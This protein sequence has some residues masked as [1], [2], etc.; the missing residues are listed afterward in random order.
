M[1][2]RFRGTSMS[3]RQS[4]I[5]FF[6]MDVFGH[7]IRL[8]RLPEYRKFYDKLRARSWEPRTFKILADN[9]DKSITYVDVGAWIGVTSYWASQVAKSV[10]AVEPDPRCNEILRGS[11][12]CYPN[13]TFLSGA[14]SPDPTVKVNAVSGFGSSETTAL[15]I[16]EGESVIVRGYSVEAIMR[17]AG[18]GPCFIKIDIEGYEYNLLTELAKFANYDIKGVQCAVHPQLY[19]KSL[20]GPWFV[21]RLRTLSLTY[22]IARL[23]PRLCKFAHVPRYQG[24]ARYF[25]RGVLLRR[26][27]KGTDFVFLNG[28]TTKQ[29]S[30]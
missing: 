8:P 15:P 5:E 16:G 4:S 25:L 27:P 1:A 20:A 24:L 21:R 22:R 14:L 26:I 6:E 17:E 7:P 23:F 11:L 19:E 10:V 18:S 28:L 13:V 29:K 12:A 3:D 2:R 9:L 30:P